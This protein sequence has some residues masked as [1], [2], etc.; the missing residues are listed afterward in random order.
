MTFALAPVIA[1]APAAEA[2]SATCCFP[3]AA[4]FGAGAADLEPG[5]AGE[6]TA[7]AAAGVVA[8][9]ASFV[10]LPNGLGCANFAFVFVTFVAG[11]P[12]MVRRAPIRNGVVCSI[13]FAWA[14]AF[15]GRP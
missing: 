10:G 2:D 4:G 12:G 1:P 13:L 6:P 8:D 7:G 14:I 11:V 5:S 9:E 3:G 15:T